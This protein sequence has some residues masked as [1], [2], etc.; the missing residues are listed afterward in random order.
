MNTGGGARIAE[1][2]WFVAPAV[3][4]GVDLEILQYTDSGSGPKLALLLH[5]D[6]AAREFAYDRASRIG[7]LDGVLGKAREGDRVVVSM[8]SDW[9]TIWPQ[10]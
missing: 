10:E 5:H 1:R 6:D 7:K 8:R 2:S 9:N 4:Y 3:P